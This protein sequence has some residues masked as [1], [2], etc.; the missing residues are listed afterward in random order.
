VIGFPQ[1]NSEVVSL[2]K[3]KISVLHVNGA[4]TYSDC[5][6]SDITSFL[7]IARVERKGW[8]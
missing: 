2:R 3:I 4:P 5:S 7:S 8:S 6:Q 1:V